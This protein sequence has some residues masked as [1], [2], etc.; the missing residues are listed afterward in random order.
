M[1]EKEILSIVKEI[2]A[3]G[4]NA[5]IKKNVDGS[6]TVYEVKKKKVTSGK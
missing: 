2:T 5:E 6:F 3:R 4:N 1:T